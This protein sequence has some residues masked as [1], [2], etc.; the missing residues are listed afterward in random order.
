MTLKKITDEIQ[1]N[2]KNRLTLAISSKPP[3]RSN[4]DLA[5]NQVGIIKV[6]PCARY[7]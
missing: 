3:N 5:Q 4:Q 6:G 1:M 2:E 7:I